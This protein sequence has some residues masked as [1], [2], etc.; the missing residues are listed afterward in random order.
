MLP[1]AAA[2]AWLLAQR[3]GATGS[4]KS[5]EHQAPAQ[6]IGAWRDGLRQRLLA[7]PA[8]GRQGGLTALV[9][10]DDSGLS[11]ADWQLLQ[12][13]GTIHLMVISGGHVSLMAGLVY[14]LIVQLARHGLWPR[15]LPWLPWACALG[16]S[17]ALGY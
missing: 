5:G 4:V 10:G 6:G 7:L 11:S 8:F 12:D 17:A 14:G 16:F 13:T 3:I 15:R 1:G 9:L 2:Q